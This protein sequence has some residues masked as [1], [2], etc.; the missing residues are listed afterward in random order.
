MKLIIHEGFKLKHL[1]QLKSKHIF[2]QISIQKH[3]AWGKYLDARHLK[4]VGN[5]GYY[6]TKSLIT[7]TGHLLLLG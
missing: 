2:K 3:S 1:F 4:Y 5:L 7:W 6:I